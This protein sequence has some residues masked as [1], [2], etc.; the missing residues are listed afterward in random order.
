MLPFIVIGLTSGAVYALAGLGLVLTYTTSGVFN[1]AHG[2]LATVSAFVFYSLFVGSHWAW[3]LAAAVSIV[4]VGPLM[5]LALELLARRIQ[6]TTLVLQVASTVGLLLAIE[7]GVALIYGTE[8]VRTVPTFLGTGSFKVFGASVQVSQLVTFLF[9]VVVT[10]VLTGFLR[11]SRRGVSMRAVVY[12]PELL[13]IAGTSPAATRRLA[14]IIGV[15]LAAASGVLFA[16]V[17][18]LDPVQLTL[19]VVAAYGAAAIG[20]FRSLPMTLVGGLFI[21][22]L[23]SLCTNW[24]TTGLLAGLPPSLPFVVLFG[25][26]LLFPRRYLVLKSFTVPR[27]RPSW[28][29]PASLQLAM[30]VALLVFLALVPGF[31]GIHL[32]DWTTFLAMSTVFMSLSLLVHT[33][34]QVSLCQVS[35][36][37]IGAAAFSHLTSGSHVPWFIALALVG[38]VAVPIGVLLAIPAIRLSGLYLALATF[39]FGILLQG[40]FYT[41]H[42]MF[43]IDGIGLTEPRPSIATSD[44]SY[45]LLVLAL[46]TACAVFAISLNR[47][48][49]GRLLRGASDSPRALETS[50]TSVTMTRLLVFSICAFMAAVGGALAA[51]GQT[52]VSADS[53]QPI[54]SLTYF[55]AIVVVGRAGPWNAVLAAAGLFLIPS[56]VLG[57][58]ITTWLQLLFGLAAIG[59]AITPAGWHGVP[60]ALQRAIDSAFGRLRIPVPT[61]IRRPAANAGT[62][63]PRMD[64][65]LGVESVEVRFGGLVALDR[66]TL[67]AEPRTITGLIGPNGAGKT[68]TF[69]ACT[70]LTRPAGGRVRIAGVDVSRLGPS[71]RAR[72]GIG[73]TF[74]QP[75]LLDTLSVRDNVEAGAEGALAGANPLTQFLAKPGQRAQ[76]RASADRAMELCGISDLGEMPAMSLSSSQRRLVELA[77]CLAGRF[78]LLLL[79]EP[80]SGLDRTEATRFGQVLRQVVAER[81]VGVLLVEHD[82]SLVLELCQHVYVLDFGELIFEGS[83]QEIIASPIVRAAYLGDVKVEAAVDPTHTLGE[84]ETERRVPPGSTTPTVA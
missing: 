9:V 41:Q 17:L 25:V 21:G 29:A 15:T 81:G 60:S 10:V 33:S 63:M 47:S 62:V 3:P 44:K 19:L 18:S 35:F 70:G 11:Y 57:G 55:A 54:L 7:A 38:L 30:A 58:T 22:V 27:S 36:V 72:R 31:A 43:G 48:R 71:A 39:G 64:G 1:F 78:G 66:V 69:N 14:W 50:G 23:A 74:Q 80:S 52:T 4:V 84:A 26:L 79:D 37:A 76:V 75:E 67:K 34:G 83:P 12:N 40:M 13:D 73:R 6:T 20:A 77:R 65:G 24:F 42:Y 82:M 68:T 53:Y 59:Y 61:L 28:T 51:A 45:Y 2:A 5:G 16:P 32:T 56:Y 46:A 8:T 49:L